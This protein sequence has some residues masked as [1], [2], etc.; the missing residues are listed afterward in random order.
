MQSLQRDIA[1]QVMRQGPVEHYMLTYGYVPLWVLVNFLS[2]GTVS[3][4][5]S[6]MK[7]PD[8]Q[9]V[10]RVYHTSDDA[11]ADMLSLLTL[12]RNKC[13]HTRSSGFRRDPVD[14][15]KANKICWPS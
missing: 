11:F 1:R 7:Q 10:A 5:Y 3:K 9:A 12:C 8:R 14:I 2:L 4:F 6:A 15:S 13:A